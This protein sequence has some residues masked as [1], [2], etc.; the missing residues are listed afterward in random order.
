MATSFKDLKLEEEETGFIGDKLSMKRIFNKEIW[1]H[2]FKIMPSTKKDGTK[3]LWMQISMNDIKYVVFTGSGI[4]QSQIQKI[5]TEAFP[6]ITT[7]IDD[8]GK[9]RFT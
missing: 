2:A 3:C 1:V 4:L 9:Y 5:A 8:N 6:I 7:I